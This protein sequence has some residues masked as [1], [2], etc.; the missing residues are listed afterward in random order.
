M[1]VPFALAALMVAACRAVPEPPPPGPDH[2]ASP[3]AAEAPAAE[4]VGP[5]SAV[6]AAPAAAQPPLGSRPQGMPGGRR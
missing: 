4:I 5:R 3:A 6:L 2:P 1:R